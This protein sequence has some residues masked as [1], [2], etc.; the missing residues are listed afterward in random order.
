MAV[1]S[2]MLKEI[3]H[4]QQ[5][6][7]E[8]SQLKLISTLTEH[9]DQ[10]LSSVRETSESQNNSVSDS[11]QEFHYNPEQG[12][13]FDKWYQRYS[14]TFRHEFPGKTHNWKRRLLLR[15][16][17]PSEF[18]RFADYILPKEPGELSF[19]SAIDTLEKIFGKQE[20]IFH[21]RYN[22]LQLKKNDSDDF[23][24]YSGMVNRQC[25]NFQLSSLTENQFKCLIF[26][27][28]LN[29]PN[30]TEIRTKLL[31]KL[32]KESD[33][34][35]QDLTKECQQQINLKQDT[36]LVQQPAT[37]Y[38]YKV[39]AK[40]PVKNTNTF[41]NTKIGSGRIPKNPCWYCGEFHYGYFCPFKRHTCQQ[42]SK[43]GHKEG[44]CSSYY[45]TQR[46]RNKRPSQNRPNWNEHQEQQQS[47]SVSADFHPKFQ[48]RRKFISATVNNF[49]V[50]F[51]FDTA[52]DITIISKTTWQQ[53]GKPTYTKT[54]NSV[55]SA[56]GNKIKII[57]ELPCDIFFKEKTVQG[58][59][60]I[61]DCSE[62]NIFG[63]NLIHKFD[64]FNK[65]LSSILKPYQ[66]CKS[67]TAQKSSDVQVKEIQLAD[68]K[69]LSVQSNFKNEVPKEQSVKKPIVLVTP[70]ESLT[71]TVTSPKYP[72]ISSVNKSSTQ[73]SHQQQNFSVQPVSETCEYQV[74]YIPQILLPTSCTQSFSSKGRGRYQNFPKPGLPQRVLN[75][76]N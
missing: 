5:K 44:F 4:V 26:I 43:T 57:G 29:S 30:D 74:Q 60:F 40:Q 75:S 46:N 56:S 52:S 65:P 76:D 36:M 1:S 8:Q 10:T 19:Q 31:A 35:L 2:D 32:N 14:D 22:C 51:Q 20:S 69:V 21:K 62:L 13:T 3:L 27:A 33:I 45:K 15:K 47:N 55:H 24:S 59:C 34:T 67:V 54:K 7:F 50:N 49:P 37:S 66:K 12:L 25:E 9:F 38:T 39:C 16:L 71:A 63:L 42:C 61:S 6:Q 18:S 23:L 41:S 64:L 11:I 68:K 17:G 28:G 70:S 72:K 58:H 53:M 73:T 48:S